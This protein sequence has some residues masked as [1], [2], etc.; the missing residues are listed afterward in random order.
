MQLMIWS[1]CL[2]LQLD[3]NVVCVDANIYSKGFN[4]L[5]LVFTKIPCRNSSDK[6]RDSHVGVQNK[7][8]YSY[9]FFFSLYTNMAVIASLQTKNYF[10]N[11]T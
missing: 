7:R 1:Y 8:L 2:K 4:C 10:Y 9:N 3:K 5:L 6:K 11:I